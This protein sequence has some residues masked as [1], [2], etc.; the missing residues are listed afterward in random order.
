MM[1]IQEVLP[2]WDRV[3]YMNSADNSRTC[4][5]ILVGICEGWD[6]SLATNV[7]VW[8]WSRSCSTCGNVFNGIFI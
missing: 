3:N 8:C 1:P 2:L 5:R 4:R 6:V 7:W